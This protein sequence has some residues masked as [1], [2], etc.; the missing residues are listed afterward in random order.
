MS[1]LP[2]DLEII[3]E[4][5]QLGRTEIPECVPIIFSIHGECSDEDIFDTNLKKGS[6]ATLLQ[7]SFTYSS[8]NIPF[9]G[10]LE[11]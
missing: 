2:V 6:S 10:R 7:E 5:Q 3:F 11:N 9:F 8:C 1:A 4:P